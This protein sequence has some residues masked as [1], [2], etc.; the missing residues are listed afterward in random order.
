MEFD[1][2][3][4]HEEFEDFKLSNGALRVELYLDKDNRPHFSEIGIKKQ[5]N[6]QEYNYIYFQGSSQEIIDQVRW[7]SSKLNEY[8]DKLKSVC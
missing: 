6:W 7:L 4:T 8:A 5:E 1:E 3:G 2:Y